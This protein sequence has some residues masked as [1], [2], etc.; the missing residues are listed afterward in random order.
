MKLLLC[1]ET[2][3][4]TFTHATNITT[5]TEPEQHMEDNDHEFLTLPTTHLVSDAEPTDTPSQTTPTPVTLLPSPDVT[6]SNLMRAVCTDILHFPP[7]HLRKVSTTATESNPIITT[8]PLEPLLH[9]SITN[10]VAVT[11]MPPAA[12][13]LF[14]QGNEPNTMGHYP[15][16]SIPAPYTGNKNEDPSGLLNGGPPSGIHHPATRITPNLRRAK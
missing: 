9:A 1:F 5:P 3:L 2:M 14:P 16:G 6:W 8:Q 4:H 10:L 15:H 13:E 12:T 11:P 7:G